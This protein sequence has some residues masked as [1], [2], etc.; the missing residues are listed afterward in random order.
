M[1]LNVGFRK[2]YTQ[3]TVRKVCAIPPLI[4]AVTDFLSQRRHQRDIVCV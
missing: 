3:P 2:A 1:L 4:G